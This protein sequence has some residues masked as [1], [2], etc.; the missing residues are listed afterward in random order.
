MLINLRNWA[1]LFFTGGER[2]GKK[3]A[4]YAEN[5]AKNCQQIQCTLPQLENGMLIFKQIDRHQ[6]IVMKDGPIL[7]R[8][9][10]K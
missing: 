5:I 10:S 1:V 4:G 3:Y 6:K 2:S 7:K 9:V 8:K